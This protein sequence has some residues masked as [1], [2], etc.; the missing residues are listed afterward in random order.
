[1]RSLPFRTAATA[2]LPKP[3]TPWLVSFD[4][5]MARKQFPAPKSGIVPRLLTGIRIFEQET[6]G[7]TL[8]LSFLLCHPNAEAA[9][10]VIVDEL[11]SGVF[12]CRLNFDQS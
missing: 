2:I 10:L 4:A 7:L 6:N 12:E 1:L 8:S 5:A 9:Q 11:D 3:L